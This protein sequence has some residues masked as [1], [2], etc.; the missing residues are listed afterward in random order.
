M[1]SISLCM[2]VKNEEE[3]LERCLESVGDL[4]DE[5]I[6]VDTG[7]TDRTVEIA[8][9]YTPH[10]FHFEWVDDF[11]Q[12]RNFSFSKATKDYIFWLDAD[13]TLLP[14]DQLKMQRLKQT[15]DPVLDAVSM[16]YHIA[17]DQYG[18]V[19]TSSRRFRLVKRSKHYQWRGAVH[20]MLAVTGNALDSDI[21]VTHRKERQ[22][23][24]RNLN[25][26]E[27]LLR[28]GKPF[29]PQDQFHYAR[30]LHQRKR[31]EEAAEYY[32]KFV[33]DP[34]NTAEN[35]IYAYQQL[36]DCYHMLGDTEKELSSTF[37]TFLF[38][39]PRPECC[40]RLGFYFLKKNAYRQAIFWYKLA[41][42]FPLEKNSW[43]I[44]NNT[45]R[46]I[47]PHIQ[48]GL[49]Y[50]QIG[51]YEESYRHNKIALTYMPDDKD[52]LNNI[53]VLEDLLHKHK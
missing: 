31:Y 48:L 24:D 43:A 19:I 50:Y 21:V 27:K 44:V 2:I 45:S 40:C 33:N 39:I 3:T 25:I 30:E 8:S 4:V 29:T 20:E 17:F 52:I 47:L 36:A 28:Q 9:R 5:I 18:N 41:I 32:L 46:S 13:D 26:Y 35:K 12:V 14:D 51:E 49:C 53:L 16:D 6:I 11:S 37:Q 34:N 1:I 15:L 7:S 42:D 22:V 38:D 23:T 10:V